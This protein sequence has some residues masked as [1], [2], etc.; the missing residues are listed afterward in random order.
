[1]T[2][3]RQP[4]TAV[5]HPSYVGSGVCAGEG[6][7]TETNH[8][9]GWWRRVQVAAGEDLAAGLAEVLRQKGVEDGVDTRVSI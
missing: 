3:I 9:G 7:C 5:P 4:L 2:R 8:L 6:L 1:M